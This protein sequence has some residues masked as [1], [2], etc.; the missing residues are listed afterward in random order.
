[1]TQNRT[2]IS[3]NVEYHFA[4]S[5]RVN[6]GGNVHNRFGWCIFNPAICHLS[7]LKLPKCFIS[8]YFKITLQE[9][10]GSDERFQGIRA[11]WSLAFIPQTKICLHL[12]RNL[13]EVR[14]GFRR[15]R[16]GRAR[17]VTL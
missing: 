1:M 4:G 8:W 12:P 5:D 16:I 13:E 10:L 3:I 11:T 15:G 7:L 6:L 17:Y 2:L 14:G 9:S